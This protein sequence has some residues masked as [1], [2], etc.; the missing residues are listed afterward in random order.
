[1]P[2]LDSDYLLKSTEIF[3]DI[4]IDAEFTE[5]QHQEV[6]KVLGDFQHRSMDPCVASL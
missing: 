4:C 1:M 6:E 3:L 2:N 5:T